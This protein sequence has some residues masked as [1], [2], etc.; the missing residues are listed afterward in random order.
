VTQQ[1]DLIRG[2]SPSVSKD[3]ARAVLIATTMTTSMR[4]QSTQW[5]S[6][7]S[8][9]RSGS[10]RRLGTRA[11]PQLAYAWSGLPDYAELPPVLRS[12]HLL[13]IDRSTSHERAPTGTKAG[14]GRFTSGLV[15]DFASSRVSALRGGTRWLSARH[16]K[17]GVRGKYAKVVTVGTV[18]QALRTPRGWG[19]ATGLAGG[20]A[21]LRFGY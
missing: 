7:A 21:W 3:V 5:T 15:V 10:R 11:T 8:G 4:I 1:P 9:V 19:R 13:H 14:W 17:R 6:M 20:A 16:A 2:P 12:P 18:R